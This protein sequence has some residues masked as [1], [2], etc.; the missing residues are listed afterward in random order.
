MAKKTKTIKVTNTIQKPKV[1]TPG[2][3]G[4]PMNPK[5]RFGY[6]GKKKSK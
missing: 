4:V 2:S 1:F 6:G 5:R 3:A